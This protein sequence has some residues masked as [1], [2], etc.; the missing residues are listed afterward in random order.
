[1]YGLRVSLDG[2]VQRGERQGSNPEITT[3][4]IHRI[5]LWQKV[6][7]YHLLSQDLNIRF[8]IPALD[9]STSV[10]F[11]YLL[12]KSHERY[13]QKQHDRTRMRHILTTHKPTQQRTNTTFSPNQYRSDTACEPNTSGG[14][15][16]QAEPVGRN[17][18]AYTPAPSNPSSMG[19]LVPQAKL[20]PA[21]PYVGTAAYFQERLRA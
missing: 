8:Q 7:K 5:L 16:P 4:R 10:A 17:L 1:M 19:T 9:S 12:T 21:Q 3:M 6:K 15:R 14:W 20:L 18:L 11:A 13:S 2:Q